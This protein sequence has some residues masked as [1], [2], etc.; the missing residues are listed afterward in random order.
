MEDV[1][2]KQDYS[3]MILDGWR[4]YMADRD[5][6][7]YTDGLAPKSLAKY[8]SI[9]DRSV[10]ILGELGISEWIEVTKKSCQRYAKCLDGKYSPRTIH[11]DLIMLI[12]VINYLIAEGFLPESAKVRW[13]LKKPKGST[14]Y[15]YTRRQVDR[16]L[17]FC[18]ADPKLHY[19]YLLILVL[20][21][22]GMRIGEAVNV[23]MTDIDLR[24]GF[25]TVVDERFTTVDKDSQRTVKNSDSR[26]IPMHSDLMVASETLDRTRGYLILSVR[27]E[28]ADPNRLRDQ[29]VKRVI[30]PLT[31]E[32]P[33]R[34][35]EKGLRR[36]DF[37][38]SAISSSAKRLST[39]SLRPTFAI[40]SGTVIPKS[41]SDT[42]I[43]VAVIASR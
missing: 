30:E 4:E 41:S 23:R 40:G 19:L 28:K 13:K 33:T 17:E 22:T 29:F 32:F 16:M 39:V 36:A 3:I 34:Q 31:K 5:G 38:A 11:Q 9:R 21:R 26:V 14:R 18:S 2:E 20:S 43:C 25:I 15:C 42:A 7:N 12:T 37:T 1:I 27:G 24:N 10:N 8:S 6:P 35:G